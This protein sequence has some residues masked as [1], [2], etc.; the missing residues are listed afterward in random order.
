MALDATKLF[1]K[2]GP[3][4]IHMKGMIRIYTGQP[5]DEYTALD[6]TE[7]KANFITAITGLVNGTS[8]SPED[9]ATLITNITAQHNTYIQ[10]GLTVNKTD[11]LTAVIAD[12][13]S[14]FHTY[15]EGDPPAIRYQHF[16]H[17]CKGEGEYPANQ[18]PGVAEDNTTLVKC[19]CDG[20]GKTRVPDK[21][22]TTW[23]VVESF[24]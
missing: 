11:V 2:D 3:R 15:E 24:Q 18:D 20:I 13:D 4:R 10:N 9:K 19:A 5:E 16:H 23:N 1:V 12:I 8:L 14:M 22:T 21:G 7:Q 6:Q 17:R